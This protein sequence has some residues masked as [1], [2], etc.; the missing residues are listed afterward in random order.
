PRPGPRSAGPRA[1]RREA[2]GRRAPP[3]RPAVTKSRLPTPL[4]GRNNMSKL[5]GSLRLGS[6]VLGLLAACSNSNT[7]PIAPTP[8]APIAA[9]M[10]DAAASAPADPVK[11]SAM[12]TLDMGRQIFRF[13]T[14]GDEDFWGGALKLHQA[15]AGSANGGVGGGV[16]P[17]TALAV[18]LKVDADAVPAA[19]ASGIKA[20]TVDLNDPKN[21]LALLKANAVVGLTGFFDGSGALT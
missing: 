16:S 20:G 12:S 7:S 19:V 14:F 18:G 8:D 11:D 9:A 1:A 13:D 4:S 15:I 2:V 17:A 21:T 6:T 3:A 10:P 5:S